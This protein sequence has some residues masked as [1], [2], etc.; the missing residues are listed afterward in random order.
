LTVLALG[1]AAATAN[2][3]DSASTRSDSVLVRVDEDASARARAA[4]GQA[5]DAESAR[6][7][8]AGWR[9]YELSE[10]LTLAEARRRLAGVDAAESIQRDARLRA[11]ETPN[12]THF[13]L[14]WPLSAID[15]A[16]GWDVSTPTTPV[17]VAVIDTG[18]DTDHPD[19]ADRL[20]TN[21]GEIA[22][23]GLDDDANGYVDDVKGWNFY[24]GTN[25]VYSAIDGDSHGTHVAGI[26]AARRGNGAGIAGV[27]DNARIMALKFLKPGG[28]YTSDAIVAIQ[29][30]VANGATVINASWGGTGYS[31]ALCEAIAQAGDAGVV[32]VAASGN[33]ATDNDSAPL[34]PANCPAASLVSVAATTPV[35][36]LATFSNRG[37][38]Q[39]DVGAPG[40]DVL[41]TIPG[42]LYGY[43]S[44][45]SMAAPVVSGIAAALVGAHPELAPWQ[46]KA[47]IMTGGDPVAALAGATVSG[48]R[49][50]L[51]GALTAAGS[52][53][54]PDTTPPD[55]FSTVSPSDGLATTSTT[56]TFR[57][58]AASDAQSGVAGYRL[59]VDEAVVAAVAPG[60]TSASPA[61]PLSEGSHRWSV[62]AL[63]GVGNIRATEART[64]LVDRTAPSAAAPSSPVDGARV[65]GAE[66]TL[67]WTP[68]ADAVS[69]VAGYRVL[70]DGAGVATVPPGARSARVRLTPGRHT[71]NVLSAD[72]AGNESSSA[73]SIFTVTGQ[74]ATASPRVRPLRVSAPARVASGTRPLL[75]LQLT[76]PARVVFSV[77]CS[78]GSGTIASFTRSSRDGASDVAVPASFARRMRPA[79]VYVITAWAPGGLKDAVRLVVR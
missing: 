21:A 7:L 3:A 2:A 35:D 29:Y 54:G 9:A 12:D 58:S 42:G 73:T 25:Q 32:F 75:R 65:K 70:L 56:P 30:A 28:G 63:D 18:L 44:G 51:L 74:A 43:K 26:V 31:Q 76:R 41:S 55:P 19:L 66:V 17:T 45:T 40:L 1:S 62:S 64:L 61:A 72:A 20:W 8:L 33:S 60:V 79:G 77:R 50:D 16:A 59:T 71:W 49:V 23:N 38:V 24:D 78:T 48:R 37:A 39:V 27:A 15:A 34:W 67:A 22:A 10:P 13:A 68:S 11:F 57:W 4:V 5:L 52:G 53:V 14:Q 69:G 36:A 47:A 6:S 46:T